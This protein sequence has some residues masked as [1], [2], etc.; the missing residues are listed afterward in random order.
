MENSLFAKT[1][2]YI[3][4]L[5]AEE[6][7]VLRKVIASITKAGI[8]Q[9]SISANQGKLLQVLMKACNAQRVLELGTLGGYST[10]W[11]ARAL[12]EN[13]KIITIE[14]DPLHAALS[15]RNF[16]N[17][18]LSGKIEL[19]T[20][21]AIEVLPMLLEKKAGP[22]DFIFIDADK[23]PYTE[24]FNYAVKLSRP[25][26]I[27][28]CDNVIRAAKVLEPHSDD[29]K[30]RGVQRFNEMLGKN[31]NVMATILQ[32]VGVK[33]HDGMAVAVVTGYGLQIL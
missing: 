11:M 18:G 4:K 23:P 25:G 8:S 19:I 14:S 31:K 1:D 5:L 33:E 28:V 22:F 20:G 3:S 10:I 6:D 30:V 2:D 24:Y 17:A 13:G 12:P 21:N 27:I 15:K 9:A 29:E 32:T 7:D 16:E 26:T